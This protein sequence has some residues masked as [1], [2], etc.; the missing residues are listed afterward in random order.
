MSAMITADKIAF[1][2]DAVGQTDAPIVTL[3]SDG[4]FVLGQSFELNDIQ[5]IFNATHQ[6]ALAL[7]ADRT[8]LDTQSEA[9]ITQ[10]SDWLSALGQKGM[11]D[12][13][14]AAKESL[15]TTISMLKE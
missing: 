11:A 7:Y 4:F 14:V 8:G 5:L 15:L 2:I 3:H 9:K 6:I 1:F 10:V 13:L 12:D